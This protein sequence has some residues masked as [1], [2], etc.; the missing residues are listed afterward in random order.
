MNN[1]N[2]DN[3]FSQIQEDLKVTG[4]VF[5]RL[6][7]NRK[8]HLV[9][10]ARL[11]AGDFAFKQAISTD[12]HPTILS[13]LD[14]LKM[15]IDASV[16]MLVSTDY[17]LIAD[18]MN[19]DVRGDEFF[20][21]ELIAL[22]EEE[23]SASSIAFIHQQAHQFVVIPVL[24]PTPIA[25]LCLSFTIDERMVKALQT[26]TLSQIS[27]LQVKNTEEV[28]NIA[29]SLPP[30]LIQD[31]LNLVSSN[32]QKLN[33]SFLGTMGKQQ[34]VTL[35]TALFKN[36][37]FTILAVLQRS[38]E[39]VLQPTYRLRKVLFLLS[40]MGWVLL[41]GG[42]IVIART[43]TKPVHTLVRGSREIEKGN[44]EYRVSVSTE[45]EIGELAQAFNKMGK[46]LLEKEK[47]RNL[48]GKVI[49]P[50]VATELLS[51]EIALGGEER[52]MTAFFSD[53]ADFTSISEKMSPTDLLSML[54][55]YLSIM[56]DLI[57]EMEGTVDKFIGDSI[58]A[59]W[60]APQT[61]DSHAER[62]VST[63]ILCQK[64]LDALHR[65]WEKQ[66]RYCLETRIGINTGNMVV[67]NMGSKDRMDYTII[68]DAVNLASRLESANKYY[69]SKIL[70]SEFTHRLVE[71]RFLC[72]EL[73]L[74][75]VQGKEEAIRV[76][77]VLDDQKQ[78]NKD[79]QAFNSLFR[80]G[81]FLFRNRDFMRAK[82]IFKKSSEM[83]K[84][85]DKTSQLYLKRIEAFNCS[86][87]SKDWDGA[88]PLEK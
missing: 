57:N 47:V 88:Y 33:K 74:V 24:A 55:E 79:Q 43:V 45:D 5:T 41:L 54:N 68:G 16:M 17:M 61:L 9:E 19:P 39:D 22:A 64:K 23:G 49:S 27:L 44:Y 3:A 18:T 80:E 37:E 42:S 6:T 69:G 35:F 83:K 25:W 20:L 38:L 84:E 52:V 10:G 15:R 53:I 2:M 12:D 36:D 31:L 40:V 59:F 71:D 8:K 48:L 11:L 32:R 4:R 72:R 70:I 7:N 29:S 62:A 28:F 26:L 65:D 75:C 1:A 87:P 34:Y 85:G 50:N 78:V 56:T 63:A 14:N 51:R 58:V 81:L 76:F 13:A 46:G 86:P 67:G 21:P 66:G 82:D 77:E 73:D 30:P 60:G